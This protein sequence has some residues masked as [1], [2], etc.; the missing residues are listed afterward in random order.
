MNVVDIINRKKENIHELLL[1]ISSLKEEYQN[2]EKSEGENKNKEK[3][4]KDKIVELKNK[5]EK[6]LNFKDNLR[7]NFIKLFINLGI[8][9]AIITIV[10]GTLFFI[11]STQPQTFLSILALPSFALYGYIK[12]RKRIYGEIEGLDINNIIIAINKIK[13]NQRK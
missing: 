5:E 9:S 11:F 6:I 3:S 7:R 13:E 1:Q 8:F 2:L 4:L 10:V 12:E